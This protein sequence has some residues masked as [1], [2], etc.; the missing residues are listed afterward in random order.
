MT[1]RHGGRGIFTRTVTRSPTASR[2]FGSRTSY[3][4]W[5]SGSASRRRES[6]M[7]HEPSMPS[8]RRSPSS[9]SACSSGGAD[10]R[11]A[12][13][14]L[15]GPDRIR[16]RQDLARRRGELRA[17]VLETGGQVEGAGPGRVVHRRRGDRSRV[18]EQRERRTGA[19]ARLDAYPAGA[20][21]VRLEVE[22]RSAR[23]RGDERSAFAKG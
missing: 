17:H 22:L 4:S 14:E 3:R 13:L 5:A 11:D 18:R 23:G 19:V 15:L 16:Q 9:D 6:W 20:A 1:T 12:T 7:G 2:S 21:A 8:L 10:G